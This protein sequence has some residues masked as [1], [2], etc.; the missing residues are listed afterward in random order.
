MC[1][2][3][4]HG[5]L[6][7]FNV[8][9]SVCSFLSSD[10]LLA[11]RNL[12]FRLP[13]FHPSLDLAYVLAYANG[14]DE[15][16]RKVNGL[17]NGS[18]GISIC[19]STMDFFELDQDLELDRSFR[20]LRDLLSDDNIHDR[21]DLVLEP[22]TAAVEKNAGQLDRRKYFEKLRSESLSKNFSLGYSYISVFDDRFGSD[23]SS[24]CDIF[25]DDDRL[26]VLPMI[27]LMSRQSSD[28]LL[29]QSIDAYCDS[30][31]SSRG[32]ISSMH[33]QYYNYPSIRNSDNMRRFKAQMS[34]WCA[35]TGNKLFSVP[36]CDPDYKRYILDFVSSCHNWFMSGSCFPHL[37]FSKTHLR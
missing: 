10:S 15:W 17:N 37:K 9:S 28:E 14:T 27:S 24:I 31:H 1:D 4:A 36:L 33:S 29:L 19:W 26:I 7:R 20:L 22:L 8:L 2:F 35:M 23:V 12:V 30:V 18:L 16:R 13:R 21:Y 6:D 5:L 32:F 3:N 25:I 11:G 34:T